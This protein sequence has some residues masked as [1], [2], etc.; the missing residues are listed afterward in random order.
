MWRHSSGARLGNGPAE[1]NKVFS[2]GKAESAVCPYDKVD[3][4]CL[5]DVHTLEI[6]ES[7]DSSGNGS[8]GLC[9]YVLEAFH[10]G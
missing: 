5:T 6:I 9:G 3:E 8:T 4:V 10:S 1:E 2:R 7:T